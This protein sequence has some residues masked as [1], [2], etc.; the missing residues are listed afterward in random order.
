MKVALLSNLGP[1]H[2]ARNRRHAPDDWRQRQNSK[3]KF[4]WNFKILYASFEAFR[5]SSG[6][7][8]WR[9]Y[10][11]WRAMVLLLKIQ[12]CY[13]RVTGNVRLCLS[14]DV[15]DRTE[16]RTSFSHIS[17]LPPKL[18]PS[19]IWPRIGELPPR[20]TRW[21]PPGVQPLPTLAVKTTPHEYAESRKIHTQ[22]Q[23][24]MHK[25]VHWSYC[26]KR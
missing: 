7:L 25:R 8:A 24:R 12:F 4:R 19:W 10:R 6:R 17:V 18:S 23:T 13:A 22:V 26:N 14:H 11:W 9:R 21:T 3:Q 1:N 2:I 5:G 16:S 15:Q 20:F